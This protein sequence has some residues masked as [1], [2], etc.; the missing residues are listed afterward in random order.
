MRHFKSFF[1]DPGRIVRSA[2]RLA[3]KPLE[4]ALVAC[5]AW[6]M[7]KGLGGAVHEALLS[8][9]VW[10]PQPNLVVAAEILRRVRSIPDPTGANRYLP[11]R[12]RKIFREIREHTAAHVDWRSG[13]VFL[14]FG[15]GDRNPMGLPLLA[16]LAGAS[17]GIALEPGAIMPAASAAL[18]ETLWDVL[19]EPGAYGLT[20]ADLGR[21][22]EAVNAD[23]LYRG[24]SLAEILSQGQLALVRAPGQDAGLAAESID[25]VYSRSVL[26]HVLD[27]EVTMSRL[28]DALKPGGL[29]LHDIALDSHD[30]RDIVSFYYLDKGKPSDR[31][32]GL[33]GR[34]LSDY[35]ALFESLGCEIE[36]LSAETLPSSA[37]DRGRL[38]PKFARYNDLDLL[39]IRAKILVH[40]A[41][42]QPI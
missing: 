24:D 42:N 11:H 15:A 14:N 38:L 19:R 4:K 16:V 8:D 28:V 21:L 39:T 29:M 34:R 6:A 13:P 27:L 33:N 32:A 1:K 9:P 40:K 7:R 23:A 41:S 35:V 18:Q 3:I 30:T 26:E 37:I 5:V 22:R 36:I 17:K 31:F 12:W 2:L 10:T 25:L 20:A